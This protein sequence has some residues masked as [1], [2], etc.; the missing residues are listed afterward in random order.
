[1]LTNID[2]ASQGQKPITLGYRHGGV[3]IP[4]DFR[5]ASRRS[6]TAFCSRSLAAVCCSSSVRRET[7][8]SCDCLS[9]VRRSWKGFGTFSSPDCPELGD[10]ME[11][12][13][14]KS[15]RILFL[16][17]SGGFV[18]LGLPFRKVWWGG[19][20]LGGDSGMAGLSIDRTIGNRSDYRVS[21][22]KVGREMRYANALPFAHCLCFLS[23]Y[24]SHRVQDFCFWSFAGQVV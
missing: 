15:S 17:E 4:R 3:D 10:G 9:G 5:R 18:L 11:M 16:G 6:V 14:N 2:V 8:L 7:R 20:C 24:P 13:T 12:S 22:C 23:R 19:I 21:L 1:M